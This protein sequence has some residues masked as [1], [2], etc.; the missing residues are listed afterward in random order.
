VTLV[1][2]CFI[3]RCWAHKAE[4]DAWSYASH[5]GVG[6]DDPQRSLPTP[7]ILCDSVIWEPLNEVSGTHY[8]EWRGS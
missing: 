4:A 7:N 3:F 6:L 2:Q 1:L 5:K 8:I